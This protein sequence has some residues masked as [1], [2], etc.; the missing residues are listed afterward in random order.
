[1]IFLLHLI[2]TS[3]LFGAIWYIQLVHYPLY[4]F[5]GEKEF[6]AYHLR[7]IWATACVVV[8][9]MLL[10][11][12][13]GLWMWWYAAGLQKILFLVGLILI[14]VCWITTLFVQIP[15]HL[16][17]IRAKEERIVNRLIQMNWIRTLAWSL[18]VGL[19]LKI[20]GV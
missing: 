8:P 4:R 11:F 18:R 10:E 13:T 17:L 1:M 20:M 15:C 6:S 5:V 19:L 7:N 3:A 12:L 9:L 16:I 2:A 14:G